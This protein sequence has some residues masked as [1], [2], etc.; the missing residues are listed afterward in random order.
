MK[1]SL[2]GYSAAG[3]PLYSFSQ[4]SFQNTSRSFYIL[5]GQI[6]KQ[7]LSDINSRKI[8]YFLL[9]NLS[10]S[11]LLFFVNDKGNEIF[12]LN[13]IIKISTSKFYNLL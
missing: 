8:F 13:K 10:K 1:G 3:L 6:L 12:L 4:N 9:L 5:V 7:I 2:I 11:I